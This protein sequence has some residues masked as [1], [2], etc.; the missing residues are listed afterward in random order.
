MKKTITAKVKKSEVI[1]RQGGHT[2][3][4]KEGQI[5]GSICGQYVYLSQQNNWHLQRN[6]LSLVQKIN[7]IT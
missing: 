1:D 2:N 4:E 3:P 7:V 6:S 5:Y